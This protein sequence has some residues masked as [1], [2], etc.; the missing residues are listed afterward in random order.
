MG[1]WVAER[2]HEKRPEGM[3]TLAVHQLTPELALKILGA[4]RVCFLDASTSLVE[5]PGLTGIDP[6]AP[7]E[8]PGH[9]LNPQ[10]LMNLVKALSDSGTAP[11]AWLV[12]LPARDMGFGCRLSPAALK[13]A[14]RA[15]EL[16][17]DFHRGP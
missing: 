3:E 5:E 11:Q 4:D 16:V 9:I 13:G 6:D 15:V 14:R 1:V 10:A 8:N 17:L 12:R 7:A 2:L